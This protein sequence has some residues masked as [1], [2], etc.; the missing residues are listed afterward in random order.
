VTWFSG[1]AICILVGACAGPVFAEDTGRVGSLVRG[2]DQSV[3]RADALP[4]LPPPAREL[5]LRD[6][7]QSTEE[8]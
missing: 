3:L 1:A 2:G 4:P 7:F 6:A 8:T 5:T